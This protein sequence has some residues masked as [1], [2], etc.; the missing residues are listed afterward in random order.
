MT[1]EANAILGLVFWVYSIERE[2]AYVL[3]ES[4]VAFAAWVA[5]ELCSLYWF[6]LAVLRLTGI[7]R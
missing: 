6:G 2:R 7:V 4:R 5:G 1:I 3:R